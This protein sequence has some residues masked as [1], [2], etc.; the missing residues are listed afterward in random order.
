MKIRTA[1][2]KMLRTAQEEILRKNFGLRP[3]QF[4]TELD[5]SVS[6]SGDESS[7]GSKKTNENV[8]DQEDNRLANSNWKVLFLIHKIFHLSS[9]VLPSSLVHMECINGQI[10]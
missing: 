8:D 2:E 4:E 9:C 6:S 10:S 1:Q 5:I 3:Y 7:E